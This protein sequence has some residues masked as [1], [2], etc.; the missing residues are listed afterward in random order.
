MSFWGLSASSK[1][2]VLFI[3]EADAEARGEIWAAYSPTGNIDRSMQGKLSSEDN[4]QYVR[5]YNGLQELMA[6]EVADFVRGNTPLNDTTWAAFCDEQILEGC[7]QNT[8][9]MQ[10]VFD[11]LEGR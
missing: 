10:K 9:I 5:N 3:N 1:I 7:N 6:S 8:A 11:A 4:S 2:E